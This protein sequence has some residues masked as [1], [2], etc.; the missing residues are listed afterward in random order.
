MVGLNKGVKELP[1]VPS[2]QEDSHV[3]LLG[4]AASQNSFEAV[5]AQTLKLVLD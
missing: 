1:R 3:V 4:T 5:H 2:Q